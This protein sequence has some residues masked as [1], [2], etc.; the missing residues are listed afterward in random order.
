MLAANF[1]EGPS[2]LGL[3]GCWVPMAVCRSLRRK[4]QVWLCSNKALLE[5]LEAGRRLPSPG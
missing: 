5:E 4:E 3:A 1:P 2:T